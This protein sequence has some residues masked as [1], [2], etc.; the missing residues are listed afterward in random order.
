MKV[1][2]GNPELCTILGHGLSELWSIKC[3]GGCVHCAS[4]LRTGPWHTCPLEQ[5]RKEQALRKQQLC[6]VQ[7]WIIASQRLSG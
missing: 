6:L 1:V 5:W 3:M 4:T 2:K 7:S